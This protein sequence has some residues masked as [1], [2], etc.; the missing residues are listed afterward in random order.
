MAT[1]PQ[2]DLANFELIG[3]AYESLYCERT[4]P[5]PRAWIAPIRASS[6]MTTRYSRSLPT[7][8]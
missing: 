5:F 4:D 1:A 7:Q 6:Q 2:D 3:I 8:H